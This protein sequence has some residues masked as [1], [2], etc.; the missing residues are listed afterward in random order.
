LRCG[1]RYYRED[2]NREGKERYYYVVTRTHDDDDDDAKQIDTVISYRSY[3][4]LND[5]KHTERERECDNKLLMLMTEMT[6]D[7]RIM[8][9]TQSTITEKR[10]TCCCLQW[11]WNAKTSAG[12]CAVE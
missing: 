1:I 12:E 9:M 7:R 2:K 8:N 5:S 3:P 6:T 10:V 4:Y 11:W